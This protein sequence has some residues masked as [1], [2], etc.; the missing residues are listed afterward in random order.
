[1]T[2]KELELKD[3]K[4]LETKGEKTYSCKVYVP[5]TDIYEDDKAIFLDIDIPGVSK[6]DVTVKLD[7]NILSIDAKIRPE[8]Y[9]GLQPLYGEYNVGHYF[10]EFK[11][12][13][14]VEQD[15][16]DANVNNG[17]LHLTLHKLEKAQPRQIPI[18]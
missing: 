2:A 9:D 8:E 13:E 12:G 1:M 11:I 18:K 3:K 5:D 10:R 4:E 17:V 15:K 16:I 14:R 7:N 6:K